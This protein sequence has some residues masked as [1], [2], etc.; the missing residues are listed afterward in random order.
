MKRSSGMSLIEVMVA[1]TIFAIVAS[2]LYGGFQQTAQ[3]KERVE[4]SLD[5][6][7]EIRSGMERMAQEMTTAYTSTQRNIN[8][9]L[10]TMQT[11]FV[12]KE[13]GSNTKI[14]FS[15]F[16]HR[17]LYRNA[18]ESDQNELAYYVTA[19][20]NDSTKDVLA[21]REQRRV[22][23]DLEKGG[24]IQVLIE[25]V[26]SFEVQFFDPLTKEWTTNW[27]TTQAGGQPNR[28]P[29]QAKLKITVP[30][31]SGKGPDQAFGTRTWFPI[32]YALNFTQYKL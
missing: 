19:D 9:A 5:R 4:S 30:N 27:D 23:M 8:E 22:D 7:H 20:P 28:L 11:G 31:L 10:R 21:R 32:T 6:E 13:E 15:S 12:G 14:Y 16:S 29:M 3:I 1:M 26:H 17:R 18:H 25:N 24:Q 2:L